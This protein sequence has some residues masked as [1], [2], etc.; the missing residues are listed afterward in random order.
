MIGCILGTKDLCFYFLQ[1]NSWTTFKHYEFFSDWHISSGII[2]IG[3]NSLSQE[4]YFAR[5]L[6]CF[7]QESNL[8]SS[9]GVCMCFS[10][11]TCKTFS[12]QE[13]LYMSIFTLKKYA[14]KHIGKPESCH[15]FKI[16][17]YA[18]TVLQN[19]RYLGGS[20]VR[21]GSSIIFQ[22]SHG[23]LQCVFICIGNLQMSILF[24]YQTLSREN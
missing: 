17:F 23:Q 2:L 22:R 12:L 14:M 19:Y 5:K 11:C 7:S 21:G 10:M 16:Q 6:L 1:I 13:C 4:N 18:D 20:Q 15:S 8:G 3:T 24:C 9:T